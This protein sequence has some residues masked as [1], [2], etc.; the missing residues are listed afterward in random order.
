MTNNDYFNSEKALNFSGILI[1]VLIG[2]LAVYTER[3][4]WLWPFVAVLACSILICFS[5]FLIGDDKSRKHRIFWIMGSLIALFFFLVKVDVVAILTIVW[6]VQAAELYGPR[7]ATFL[8]LASI[9]VFTES[10][11]SLWHGEFF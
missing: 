7:R 6:V 1:I 3:S 4:T 9:T 5:V 8:A 11:L 2:S 10:D